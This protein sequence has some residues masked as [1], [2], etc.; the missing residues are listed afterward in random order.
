MN[1]T[2]TGTA[3]YMSP[4]Q[5]KGRT[6]D[7]RSDVWAFGAVLYGYCQVDEKLADRPPRIADRLELRP[8]D[9]GASAQRPAAWR[10]H[11]ESLAAVSSLRAGRL[12][13]TACPPQDRLSSSYAQAQPTIGVRFALTIHA[14]MSKPCV[15]VGARDTAG[16]QASIRRRQLTRHVSI[17]SRPQSPNTACLH[18]A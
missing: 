14:S 6:V 18:H 11:R 7:K 9:P 1:R 8:N 10:L 3:A 15:K 12:R 17:S 5:A 2:P 4:E 16:V 13:G